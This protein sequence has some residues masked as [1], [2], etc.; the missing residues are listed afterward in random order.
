MPGRIANS[1]RAATGNAAIMPTTAEKIGFDGLSRVANSEQPIA[2]NWAA[3]NPSG[4]DVSI[5]RTLATSVA[6]VAEV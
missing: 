3:T 4:Q 2:A 6:A 5:Q 1:Y